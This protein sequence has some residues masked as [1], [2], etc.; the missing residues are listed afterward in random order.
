MHDLKPLTPLGAHAPHV[1]KIGPVTLTEVVSVA[2]A[3]VAARLGAEEAVHEALTGLLGASA[4]APSRHAGGTLS[5]FWTGPDQWMVEAPIDTHEDLAHRLSEELAGKASVTE[6]TDAWCRFDL[7][8]D[9]LPRVMERL[10]AADVG[11]WQGG[12]VQRTTIDHLGCFVVCRDPKHLSVIGPR[13]SAGSLHHALLAA[14]RS[15]F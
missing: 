10:C 4:P 13:S 8:G 5:A 11:Q 14:C 2:L 1:D 9:A 6:Q 7:T 3:S 15:V 12:E